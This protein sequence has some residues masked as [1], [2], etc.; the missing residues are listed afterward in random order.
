MKRF[1]KNIVIY[2]VIFGLVLGAAVLYKGG[3]GAS[4]KKV[5]YSTLVQYLEQGKITEISIGSDYKV[6]G[7]I[8]D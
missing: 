3:A 6:T 8:G 2:L 1:A 5:R 4:N 7:K